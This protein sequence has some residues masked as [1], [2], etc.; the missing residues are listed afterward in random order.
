MALSSLAIAPMPNGTD[1]T[2]PA[3]DPYRPALL[4]LI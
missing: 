2:A 4:A 1:A 3:R